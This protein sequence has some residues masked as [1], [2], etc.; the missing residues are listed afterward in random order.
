MISCSS[1]LPQAGGQRRL[2]VRPARPHAGVR[3][4]DGQVQ[5]RGGNGK[6]FSL[7]GRLLYQVVFS[8]LSRNKLVI[9]RYRVG[10]MVVFGLFPVVRVYLV[11]F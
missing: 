8:R 4:R 3:G 5:V 2:G 11:S 7:S 1:C 10:S 6:N 9:E